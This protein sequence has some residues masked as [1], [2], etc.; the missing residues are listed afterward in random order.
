MLH[1]ELA[2][3]RTDARDLEVAADREQ[4]EANRAARHLADAESGTPRTGGDQVRGE[5]VEQDWQPPHPTDLR[6]RLG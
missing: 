2:E 3:A 4:A 5:L 1:R 6:D